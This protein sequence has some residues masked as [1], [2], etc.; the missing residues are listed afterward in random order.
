[1]LRSF[2]NNLIFM[3]KKR[4]VVKNEVVVDKVVEG[5]VVVDKVV[6]VAPKKKAKCDNCNDSGRDCSVCS[7]VFVDKF[8]A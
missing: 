1:M 8:G 4:E 6:E 5:E 3:G 2:I 7:G